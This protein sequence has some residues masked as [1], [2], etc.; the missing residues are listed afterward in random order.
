M[1]IVEANG[2]NHKGHR[3]R[4][5]GRARPVLKKGLEKAVDCGKSPDGIVCDSPELSFGELNLA[6][7]SLVQ[8]SEIRLVIDVHFWPP[9][10]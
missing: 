3:W 6:G 8:R 10:Q 1:H 2:G 9:V 7:V 4:E 5:N